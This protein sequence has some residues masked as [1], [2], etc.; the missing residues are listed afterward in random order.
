MFKIISVVTLRIKDGYIIGNEIVI[1]QECMYTVVE[2]MS[3][4]KTHIVIPAHCF[5]HR[6]HYVYNYIILKANVCHN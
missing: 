4:R 6:V 1:T 2:T 3:P 5:A